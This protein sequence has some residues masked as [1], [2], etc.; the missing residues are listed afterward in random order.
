[1][2]VCSLIGN[3]KSLQSYS[4]TRDRNFYFRKMSLKFD[5][6]RC[7]ANYKYKSGLTA[8]IKRKHPLQDKT[9]TSVAPKSPATANKK[10][11]WKVTNLNTQEV[12]NLLEQEEEFYDAIDELE[13]RVGINASMVDWANINFESPFG[14]SGEFEGR[15]AS[16]AT[17]EKCTDCDINSKTLNMQT[18]LITKLDKKLQYSQD[19]LKESRKQ[20]K[21]TQIK[22]SDAL[23]NIQRLEHKKVE[24]SVAITYKCR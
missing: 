9:A 16:V 1:M 15:L 7:S 19:Q 21:Q 20:E 11:T 6:T 13:H 2:I 24:K 14:T 5:C 10:N 8:H 23:K 22:L 17:R 12:E 4:R 3:S 18:E